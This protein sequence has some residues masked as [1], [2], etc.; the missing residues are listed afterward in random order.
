MSKRDRIGFLDKHINSILLLPYLDKHLAASILKSNLPII[1]VPISKGQRY[2]GN[3]KMKYLDLI[4][5][6]FDAILIFLKF[7]KNKNKSKIYNYKN[8]IEFEK[9]IN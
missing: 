7:F 2:Y 4:A 9:T 8:F 1:K 3:S 5:L 6:G